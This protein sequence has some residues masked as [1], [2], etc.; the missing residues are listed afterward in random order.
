MQ[1]HIIFLLS[2]L[3]LSWPSLAGVLPV[4]R[5]DETN[6]G[7]D[8]A[9]DDNF[10]KPAPS[11]IPSITVTTTAIAT[12]LS[13]V[14]VTVTTIKTAVVNT[15]ET[16]SDILGDSVAVAITPGASSGDRTMV[17]AVTPS[18]HAGST[19]PLLKREN[20]DSTMTTLATI[21][22]PDSSSTTSF[23]TGTCDDLFC[24]TEGN[25]VCMYWAG[26]T[27]WDASHGPIPGE[28]PTIVGT[29]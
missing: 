29:C 10:E 3:L 22:S 16:N 17:P 20:A 9:L 12:Q 13:I 21:T 19:S 7:S 26:L 4:A 14:T 18:P 2:S 24:N 23:Y 15:I 28:I 5:G 11:N 25:L 6:L 1:Q 8:L 27:S